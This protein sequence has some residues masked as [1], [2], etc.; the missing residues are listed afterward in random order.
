MDSVRISKKS[1]R[2][3]KMELRRK[4]EFQENESIFENCKKL[5]EI[6]QHKI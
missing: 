4:Q 5:I 1:M 3:T 2:N 6:R